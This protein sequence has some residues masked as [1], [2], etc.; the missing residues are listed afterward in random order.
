M[1]IFTLVALVALLA[2]C[3]SPAPMVEKAPQSTE[4]SDRAH[5]ELDNEMNK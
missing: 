2:G 3:A 4:R 1:K 5:Q